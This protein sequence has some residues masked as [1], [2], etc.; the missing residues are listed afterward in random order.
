MKAKL[1]VLILLFATFEKAASQKKEIDTEA[2]KNWKRLED[3]AI[4]GNG[5]FVWF[6]ENSE[7]NG[8]TL[9]LAN[10]NGKAI[11]QFPKTHSALFTPDSKLLLFS[12]NDGVHIL[13]LASGKDDFIPG[14]NE[15]KLP[16]AGNSNWCSYSKDRTHFVRNLKTGKEISYP[17][18]Q[19]MQFNTDG[20]LLVLQ[21]GRSLHLVDLTNG[22]DAPIYVG[23]EAQYIVFNKGSSKLAFMSSSTGLYSIYIYDIKNASLDSI[24]HNGLKLKLPGFDIAQ[25]QIRFSNS[26]SSLLFKVQQ[27]ARV[28]NNI[29]TII[30]DAVDVWSY[31]D[32]YFQSQQLAERGGHPTFTTLIHLLSHEIIS[33]E[34][35]LY[36]LAGKVG[37]RYALVKTK[38]NEYEAY[39]REEEVARYALLPL[40]T[41]ERR[42]LHFLGRSAIRVVLSP[43]E[44]YVTWID[45]AKGE[46]KCYDIARS[47]AYTLSGIETSIEFIN[48]NKIHTPFNISGW[49]RNDEAFIAHDEYDIW[50][51]DPRNE[52]TAVCLSNRYGRNHKVF[53][54][55]V[56][57]DMELVCNQQGALLAVSMDFYTRNNGFCW[58]LPSKPV[59]PILISTGPYFYYFPRVT[60]EYPITPPIKAK[61]ADVFIFQRQSDTLSSNVFTTRDFKKLIPVS[62]V[63]IPKNYRW[64]HSEVINWQSANGK[65]HSGILYT[66]QGLDTTEKHPI[67]FN[68]YEE[69]SKECFLNRKPDLTSTNI[70][71]PWYTSRGYIVFLPDVEQEV[72]RNGENALEAVESGADCLLNKYHWIDGLKM[73]LQ[74]HSHG[75]YLTNYIVSHSTRFA[76]AQSSAGYSDF[77]SGYGQIGFGDISLQN[78]QEVGG[79]NL[80]TT[81]WN[82]VDIYVKNSCIFTADRVKTPL[83]L[84]HNKGDGVVNFYQSLELFGAL[85]RLRKPVWLLQYDG[86]DHILGDY[87]NVLDFTIRQQQFFDHYLKEIQLPAWMVDG[88]PADLKGVKSGL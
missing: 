39:W 42:P 31:N 10:S 7:K 4:S 85:R 45:T 66:P 15:I 1:M 18:V 43:A 78:M 33:L 60:T 81:P 27:K 52:K 30:T 69:H 35:S 71:I 3:Y 38:N 16:E 68:Y 29:D 20:T 22:K 54:R 23:S 6:T 19:Q 57:N 73:G 8:S 26:D 32:R 63:E 62:H 56:T 34:D 87:K 58:L 59:T 2:I 80:G 76:A 65:M 74:G 21:R 53:M 64:H 9:T 40:Q 49:L 67:I 41:G 88:V 83:L 12:S 46:Y 44:K 86:E 5:K 61:F 24:T 75:G 11:S 82:G 25:E 51:V 84:M 72:A 36:K 28:R 70:N 47:K 48:F 77:I 17:D 55:P 50:R 13:K 37:D 79:N 14:G